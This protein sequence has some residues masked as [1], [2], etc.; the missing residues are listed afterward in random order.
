M[1][2][3]RPRTT[4]H[5][6]SKCAACGDTIHQLDIIVKDDDDNWIHEECLEDE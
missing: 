3:E 5:W 2:N 4:A 1:A 6:E